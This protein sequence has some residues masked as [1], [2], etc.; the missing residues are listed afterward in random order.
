MCF[1][2]YL[3]VITGLASFV[4][5][6]SNTGSNNVECFDLLASKTNEK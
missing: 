1:S 2:S 5:G 3:L 6:I 4:L